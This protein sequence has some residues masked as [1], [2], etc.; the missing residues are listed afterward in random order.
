MWDCLLFPAVVHNMVYMHEIV[1][2]K[3]EI[4]KNLLYYLLISPV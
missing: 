1:R 2:P 4:V 3:Y